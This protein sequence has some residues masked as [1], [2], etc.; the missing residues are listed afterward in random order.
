M[1]KKLTRNRVRRRK[2]MNTRKMRGGACGACA[3]Y[4]P[5]ERQELEQ[6]I[7]LSQVQWVSLSNMGIKFN[8]IKAKAT[9]LKDTFPDMLYGHFW[10]MHGH[11][12]PV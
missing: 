11:E 6:Q 7:G 2:H 8:D 12:P 10:R 3:E 1:A 9:E 5:Q 4:T